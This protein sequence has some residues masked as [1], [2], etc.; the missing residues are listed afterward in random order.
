MFCFTLELPSYHSSFCTQI[1]SLSLHGSALCNQRYA[2]QTTFSTPPGFQLASVDVSAWWKQGRWEEGRALGF[3]PP[4]SRLQPWFHLDSKAPA[5]VSCLLPPSCCCRRSS[6]QPV[7]A[8]GLN[9]QPPALPPATGQWGLPA[10]ANP[11][12]ASLAA[13]FCMFS[14]SN[15]SSLPVHVKSSLSNS[16]VWEPLSCLEPDRLGFS[17]GST[18]RSIYI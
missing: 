2:L 7:L 9:P 17:V 4:P 12:A 15:T 10:R 1:H 13:P 8:P 18:V 6:C 11:G 16:L 3:S 14:V 5:S